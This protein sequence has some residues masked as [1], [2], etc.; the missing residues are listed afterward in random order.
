MAYKNNQKRKYQNEIISRKSNMK[1]MKENISEKA[2]KK[3]EIEN[4]AAA[5]A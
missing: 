5:A 3:N 2:A 4:M 1:I